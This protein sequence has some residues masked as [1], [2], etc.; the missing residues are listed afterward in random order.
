[1]TVRGASLHGSSVERGGTGGNRV[2][3][4]GVDRSGP[5]ESCRVLLNVLS[6]RR[7]DGAGH[8]AEV[9]VPPT[10]QGDSRSRHDGSVSRRSGHSPASSM[11]RTPSSRHGRRGWFWS[12]A[13]RA[14]LS[15]QLRRGTCRG[16]ARA[17]ATGTWRGSDGRGGGGDGRRPAGWCGCGR[18]GRR[19]RRVGDGG[20]GT[21]GRG[22][23][24][25]RSG[26]SALPAGRLAG[27]RLRVDRRG[28]RTGTRNASS[29]APRRGTWP[30]NGDQAGCAPGHGPGAATSGSSST[31]V[32]N[33]RNPRRR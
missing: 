18:S 11:M 29:P 3:P 10:H 30:G 12:Q 22:R 31:L 17:R 32:S 8:A 16:R 33:S 5:K 27:R 13:A 24:R 1:M 4:V 15:V 28:P 9:D 25:R 6:V 20:S 26:G 2:V 21:A 14:V 23:W 7:T 19:N